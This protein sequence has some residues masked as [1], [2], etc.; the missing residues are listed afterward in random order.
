MWM[1]LP[2][3]HILDKLHSSE[4]VPKFES[5][6][7]M[8]GSRSRKDFTSN[9]ASLVGSPKDMAQFYTIFTLYL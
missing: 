6:L 1:R 2:L 7:L 9:M 4:E 3:Y 5:T 8:N